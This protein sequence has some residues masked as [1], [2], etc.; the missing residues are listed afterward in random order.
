MKEREKTNKQTKIRNR[1]R[2][3]GKLEESPGVV[4][5]RENA[6]LELDL[7]KNLLHQEQK[8]TMWIASDSEISE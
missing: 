1:E 4:N 3:R 7:L 8:G 5:K 6:S 2:E